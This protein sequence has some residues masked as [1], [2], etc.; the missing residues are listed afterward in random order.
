MVMC[1]VSIEIALLTAAEAIRALALTFVWRDEN[2][3]GLWLSFRTDGG[4]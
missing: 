2:L 3:R 4:S 1:L